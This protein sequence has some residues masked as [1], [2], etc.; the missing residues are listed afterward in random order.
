MLRYMP[1]L[2][3][4]R[5][6]CI[7]AVLMHH[8]RLPWF[9]G[10]FLGVDFFF[11][12][13][14]FLITSLLASEWERTGGIAL[15]SFYLRRALRLLPALVA[16]IAASLA[17]VFI[18]STGEDQAAALKGAWSSLFFVSNWALLA[19]PSSGLGPLLMTWSLAIEDQFYIVWALSLPLLLRNLK[20]SSIL[21]ILLV[22]AACSVL[23][24]AR[25]YLET[26]YYAPSFYGTDARASGLLI[27][28]FTGL[29]YS[30]GK[31]PSSRAFYTCLRGLLA[32]G[33]L[34]LVWISVITPNPDLPVSIG[35]FAFVAVIAAALIV[36]VGVSP[37][38]APLLSRVLTWKPLMWTGRVSYGLYLW[39]YVIF[40]TLSPTRL[41]IDPM[42]LNAASLVL[43]LT[44]AALSYRFI[45]APF[46]RL[47][48]KAA[49]RPEQMQPAPAVLAPGH[50]AVI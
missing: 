6:L 42:I 24:C 41:S 20:R 3:G 17:I 10:G 22:L 9:R 50:E 48:R 18:F 11:V 32:L 26:P 2:D 47:K 16:V 28:C 25:P 39:H 46:L 4:I 34:F 31:L 8:M 19:S 5:G 27:G 21:L 13:S 1:A 23:V 7:I 14:G 33:F 49:P 30:W 37:E 44:A 35:G 43:S 40:W 38:R 29:L 45:E 15:R 36:L 12:L